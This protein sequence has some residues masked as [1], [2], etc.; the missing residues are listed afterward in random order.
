ME[1]RIF[2]RHFTVKLLIGIFRKLKEGAEDTNNEFIFSSYM[3]T[4]YE[5]SQEKKFDLD[6][7]KR[8]V[9]ESYNNSIIY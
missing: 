2:P 5:D 6:D 7:V 9:N 4:R 3:E 8:R 1:V